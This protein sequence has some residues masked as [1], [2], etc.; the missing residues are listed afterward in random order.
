MQ[1]ILY[2]HQR[3]IVQADPKRTGLF[4]GTGS[5]KTRTALMLAEGRTLV[6]APKTQVEDGNW[7]REY[8]ELPTRITEIRVISKETFRRDHLGLPRFDTVIV[9]EAHTCLG[10]TPNTRRRNSREIPRASQLYEALSAYIIDHKPTRL[11]LCTATIVKS[12]MTVLAAKWLLRGPSGDAMREFYEFRRDFYTKLPMP[13]REV[14][15]PK[16]DQRVKERLAEMVRSLGYI[17]RLEDYFDVPAQTFRT[18]HVGLSEAQEKRLKR[19]VSEYPEPIVRIG[20]RHQVENGSLA[21]D[22]FTATEFFK[23]EKVER[24][25]ELAEEFPRMVVFAKYRAQLTQLKIELEKAEYKVLVMNGDTKDRGALL[26]EANASEACIFLVQAQ[27]SAGW[28]LPQYPVMVF[29]SRTYSFVDYQQALGRILR[30]NALKKNL[31]ISLVVRG[32]V[33]EAVDKA[34]ENKQDF[35]EKLYAEKI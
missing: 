23:S 3:E 12:P 34:L 8:L 30:A 32:G 15:A 17:G 4:M 24:I 28:E 16:K 7:G 10:M 35:D 2:R 19:L 29:A 20:K 9:D 14:W 13:G 5:G 25:L 27:I 22:E 11:Y 26:A 21:G 33:D 6:I 18:V 1:D 31:Y